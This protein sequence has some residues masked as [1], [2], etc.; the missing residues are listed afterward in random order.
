M[1]KPPLSSFTKKNLIPYVFPGA[2]GAVVFVPANQEPSPEVQTILKR[3]GQQRWYQVPGGY[4]GMIPWH[5][6]AGSE[7]L[8][9]RVPKGWD[10]EHCDFCNSQVGIGETCWTADFEGGG[11]WL[12]CVTCFRTLEDE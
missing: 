4:E 10:H 8:F 12:F 2:D 3:S 11:F 5:L 7:S 9:R 6:V 1:D